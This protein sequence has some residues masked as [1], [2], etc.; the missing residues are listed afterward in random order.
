MIESSSPQVET[1]LIQQ[2]MWELKYTFSASQTCFGQGR[3]AKLD[4]NQLLSHLYYGV[5]V[6]SQD[7]KT[8]ES[9]TEALICQHGWKRAKI[10]LN[11]GQEKKKPN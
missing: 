11:F 10:H 9:S 1:L 8:R 7:G 4:P 5:S 6:R 2:K 3:A